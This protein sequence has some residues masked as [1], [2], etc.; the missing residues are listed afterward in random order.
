MQM[1][2]TYALSFFGNATLSFPVSTV[3]LESQAYD[4]A[5]GVTQAT[6]SVPTTTNGQL[7][8]GFRGATMLGGAAG[9]KNVSL[10][11]PG[12]SPGGGPASAFTPALLAMVSR[13]DSLR[14]MDWAATNDNL[15]VDWADRRLPTAPSYAAAVN[16]TEGVPWEACADLANAV[17]RDL[18]VNIPGERWDLWVNIPGERW[19]TWM[20]IPGRRSV[21]GWRWG[22]EC[23]L[24]ARCRR[25]SLLLA[26]SLCRSPRVGR[27]H[28]A[29]RQAAVRTRRPV[30]R[31]LLRVQQRAGGRLK[32]WCRDRERGD[33]CAC[34]MCC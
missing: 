11:Q 34:P 17:G 23:L 9:A 27:L 19:D 29:A 21:M 24:H 7:W 6:L 32:E 25:W 2:G 1:N 22:T 14:F 18:W 20:S 10:L 28:T 12:C 3:T 5:T 8:I 4:P 31:D 26:A 33:A 30:A 15:V 13:F 16:V